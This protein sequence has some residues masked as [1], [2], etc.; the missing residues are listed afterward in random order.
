MFKAP[1]PPAEVLL[2]FLSKLQRLLNEADFT[3]TYKLALII[4]L[5]DLAVE[6]GS[7]DGSE[8]ILTTRQIGERFVD[9]YWKQALPYGAGRLGTAPGILTQN[10]GAQAAVVSA[11]ANFRSTV[12]AVSIHQARAHPAYNA[13]LSQVC[14]TVSAQPLKY[15][16]NFGGSTDP[17]LY[18]R[19]GGGRV[20]LLP[21][22][23]YCFR[24]FHPFVQ[25]LSRARWVEHIKSNRRNTSILGEAGDLE[26]FLFSTSR[27]SL[28]LVG[29]GLKKL[30]GNSCF[31][32]G[33]ALATFDVDHFIPFV[34]YP[35]DLAQNF[36]LAH[37]GCNR[38]KSDMLAG[39]FHLERW[40]ER[41]L[42]R[43][44]ALQD[45]GER[46]GVVADAHTSH[47]IAEW[48]YKSAEASGGIA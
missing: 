12:G 4:S 45:I 10:N 18:E 6:L 24:R 23:A 27:Q 29:E 39:R 15:L 43:D 9:L 28:A 32:C 41:L 3:A 5:S 25:Q 31:Y 22:V 35:R 17:F 37:P 16:Q 1:P 30:D 11:I 21:G 34:L 14:Q 48:G 7:D 46:A 26:E 44:D 13:M 2:G 33:Q 8:L 42:K 40:L 19:L 20:R 47:R 36:V 38:S